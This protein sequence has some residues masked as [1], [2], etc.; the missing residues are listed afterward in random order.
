MPS[1]NKPFDDKLSI[2][3]LEEKVTE[4]WEKSHI[5]EETLKK[6]KDG[7]PFTFYDGPPFATGLPHYGHILVSTVKDLL[8]RYQTM[9]GRFVRRRWGWDCHGLPIEELVEK[10][11]GI[12]GKKQIE[13]IGIE[14][15][16]E[17]CRSMVLTYVA[18][19]RKMVLR[20]GRWVD[21]DNSYKTMDA[22]FME[23][24]WHGFK[25]I[26]DKGLV[27]EGRKVLLY[28]PRCETPVSNFEV[29]MD[30][31]YKDISEESV[32]V[33]FKIKGEDAYFLAWTTTPWTLPGNVALAVGAEIDY[34]R[35]KAGD[36]ILIVAKALQ[37]K[38]AEGEILSEV[39]GKDLVG[40]SYEPLFNVSEVAASDKAF[41]VYAA[42]FVT[43][44]D[45]SGIVHTAVVYGEDDYR[46]GIK[47]GLPVVPL[48]DEKGHFNEKA[49]ELIRGQYF[50]KAEK[51]VKED[52]ETRGLLLKREMHTHSY[53][54][55]WRCG[56][57]LF[58][59]AIPA[60]F[61]NIQ[62]IKP[63]LL[64]TNEK[65]VNWFPGHLKNGRY[66]K[67]VE[68]A[69]DWN[70]SR[71]RY[72]GNPIPVWKCADCGKN[73]VVGSLEDIRQKSVK[74]NEF[75][76]VRHGESTHNI[77]GFCGPLD[78]AEYTSHLTENGKELVE[79]MG[80]S[81]KGKKIDLILASPLARM[82][83]TVSILQ[84]YVDAPVEFHDALKELDH[85]G[86]KKFAEWVEVRDAAADPLSASLGGETHLDVKARLA[87]FIREV[88]AKYS[89]KTILIAT[90]GGPLWM[91]QGLLKG[92][93]NKDILTSP[94]PET[95]KVFEF[96]WQPVPFSN[97]GDVDLHRP[98][99]DEVDLRCEC[100]KVAKRTTEIFDSWVEAGS[101]PFAEYH[102]PFEN[103]EVFEHR[104]PAQFVTEYIAQT[105]AWFYV[106]HVI[107]AILFDH[108]PFEN[109][110]TT[111]TILAEDG[112][113]MSKSKMNYPD[114]WLVIDKYGVDTLRFYLMGSVVMQ[115]DNLNFSLKDMEIAHR[116]VTMLLMNVYQYFMTYASERSKE[117][118]KVD[119]S[120]VL[121]RWINARTKQLVT[122]VTDYLDTYD[123]VKATRTIEAFIDDLSTWYLRR[124]RGRE[125]AGFFP[126][127]YS[128]LLTTSKVLAPF[129]PHLAEA[130]HMN[131]TSVFCEDEKMHASV[132]LSEWPQKEALTA[133]EK[134]LL[135]D[136]EVIREAA[137]LGLALRKKLNIPVRQPLSTWGFTLNRDHIPSKDILEVLQSELNIKMFGESPKGVEQIESIE[138]QSYVST[139]YLV[140]TITPELKLEGTT[141]A[142]ERFVQELRKTQGF[143]VGE[144]AILRYETSDADLERAFTMFD[145]K[146]T[147]ISKIEKSAPAGEEFKADGL[148]AKVSVEKI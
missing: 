62:D 95:G 88:N 148:L 74:K 103:K 125:D 33:K 54:H 129:M 146:K 124:S 143:K 138:G 101:M 10:K 106:M 28:C 70:I 6:T 136:M 17:T 99:I 52:L 57:T 115:A 98:Y 66:Q 16:N 81:L 47:E 63:K 36:D 114:P 86:M 84:K 27:Y 111:G 67:S 104:F 41:K 87:K 25:S 56:T 15:F 142:L 9:Q 119:N 128:T 30:N 118:M 133:E 116:K 126:A 5:F 91:M 123:T 34:V 89:G 19:W 127:F 73:T 21:F 64:E 31:S 3:E 141:R 76:F 26:H 24:V 38:V 109:V 37:E 140:T 32:F 60:W 48:L 42:D 137:S 82:Q 11:L 39:K 112:T 1:V 117:D 132:H 12:S 59:N 4:F 120:H 58:Y 78:T 144:E 22:T 2:P 113:K 49:P 61:I 80:E 35:V 8:P 83:E 55:C 29:A 50:K 92:L 97:S 96:D 51:A 77:E 43:T 79:K 85:G 147:Y 18:E 131:L 110:L 135:E 134:L 93:S 130:I 108:A 102:Y 72:W 122:E 45:G 7:E 46:L 68:A 13:E 75:I 121:D 40:L 105:R 107:S 94:Y 14:T 69:P 71:N 20:L 44:E 23:S 100:G 145:T 139:F 90:H 65:E 53:P